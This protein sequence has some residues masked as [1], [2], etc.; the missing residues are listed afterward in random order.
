MLIILK[1][2]VWSVIVIVEMTLIFPS[3]D[4]NIY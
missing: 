2:L 4:A 3:S 1:F